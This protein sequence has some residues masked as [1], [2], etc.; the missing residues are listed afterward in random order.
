MGKIVITGA[1]SEIGLAITDQMSRLGLPMLLQGHRNMERLSPWSPPAETV[2]ADF[3]RPEEVSEFLSRLQ[4]TDILINAAACTGSGLI[5]LMSST[6]VDQLIQVNIQA[7][8]RICQAV[9]PGMCIRRKGIIINISS[10][11]ASR[12]SRGQAVYAGTKAYMEAFSRGIV[13]EYAAKGIRCNCVAPGSIEAGT[14]RPLAGMAG[15]QVKATNATGA[16]GTPEDVAQ[17]AAFLCS[18]QAG[19]INGAVLRVDG[20]FWTGV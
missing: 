11:T 15:D 5:P 3:S 19:Y 12:V 6:D 14:L 18:P 4:D 9:L 7:L 16:M 8:T 20:G 13:A 17:A 1:S 2:S 10:V